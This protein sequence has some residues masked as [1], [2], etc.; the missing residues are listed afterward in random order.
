MAT[1]QPDA[2]PEVEESTVIA[3]VHLVRPDIHRDDRGL[4]VETYRREW[5]PGSA[6]MVQGNR[7]DRVEGSLVGLHHHLRQAD[8]WYVPSGRAFVALAD[9]RESSP[10]R[11]ATL[12]FEISGDDHRGVYIPAGVAHG[13]FALTDV[14]ISYLVD[15]YY[16][17]ADEL[18]VTWDDPDLGIE[19]PVTDPLLSERDQGLLRW[20]DLPAQARPG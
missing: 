13:F 8:Y 2:V 18:G 11:G 7:A 16:D 10:S 15:R 12:T 1:C 19:W 3:G 17:P 9:L 20:A 5:I 4:F 6:E 14:T